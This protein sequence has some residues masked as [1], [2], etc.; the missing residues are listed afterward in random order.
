MA[1]LV[2]AEVK[3]F[4][5]LSITVA[6]LSLLAVPCLAQTSPSTTPSGIT[7]GDAT[8]TP[9]TLGTGGVTTAT[10]HQSQVIKDQG[11]SVTREQEQ[12]SGS[13]QAPQGPAT[14]EPG[15]K[16]TQSGPAPTDKPKH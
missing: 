4:H 7:S 8:N 3:M 16:G 5:K 13:S 15:A 10:P 6:A 11:S 14:G 9:P 1:L 2:E 12:S